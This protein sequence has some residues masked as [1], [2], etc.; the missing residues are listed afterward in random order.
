MSLAAPNPITADEQMGLQL[1]ALTVVRDDGAECLHE[2]P[3]EPLL[4]S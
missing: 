1:G 4:A 3:F 2:I